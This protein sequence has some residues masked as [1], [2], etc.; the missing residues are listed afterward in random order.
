MIKSF[1]DLDVYKEAMDLAVEIEMLIRTFPD[2]EK[3]L[4][5]DQMRR[6]S[7]GIPP[8]IA[9]GYAKRNSILTFK[10]FVNDAVGE[11]NEMMSH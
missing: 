11:A 3:Y 6:A 2:H 7:R 5:S 10:K 9:E 8:L 4:L 1:L